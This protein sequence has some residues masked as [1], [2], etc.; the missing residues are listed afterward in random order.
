MNHY[1]Y[2]ITNLVN[3]KKYIG[4]RSCKCPIDKDNYM[5][6]GKILKE[7]LKKYGK[8]KFTKRI[9][10]ICGSEEDA[11]EQEHILINLYDAYNNNN[12]YNLTTGGKGGMTGVK[13]PL[14]VRKKMSGINNWMYGKKGELC[15]N[16]GRK[17]TQEQRR[18]MSENHADFSGENHPF[19]FRTLRPY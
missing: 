19:Y 12:Y 7:A 13:M 4:K 15:C 9:I 14:N 18:K 6:S 10:A 11:Y 16:F 3:G 1:V 17:Y 2:E 8:E 5:G